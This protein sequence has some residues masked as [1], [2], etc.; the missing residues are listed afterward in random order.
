[1]TA[2]SIE[3]I[4][5]IDEKIPDEGWTVIEDEFVGV[6]AVRP[7]SWFRNICDFLEAWLYNSCYVSRDRKG[8]GRSSRG[9]IADF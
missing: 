7:V 4:P 1:M 2:H 5:P 8:C 9:N 6:Y 3:G